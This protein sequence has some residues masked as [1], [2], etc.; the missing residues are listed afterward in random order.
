MP[1]KKGAKAQSARSTRYE[2]AVRE[3]GNSE[4]PEEL[5][6][7]HDS[8]W[9]DPVNYLLAVPDKAGA[10]A[11]KIA[12]IADEEYEGTSRVVVRG[13]LNRLARKYKVAPAKMSKPE[14]EKISG[15]FLIGEI[16]L[17][18]EDLGEDDEHYGMLRIPAARAAVL[19]H[20]WYGTMH[21]DED[22]FESFIDNWATDLVGFDLAIDPSHDTR[23]GALAWVKDVT[24]SEEGQFDL[25]VE[26][27]ADGFGLGDVFRYASIEYTEDYTD[28]ETGASYGPT[29]LGCAAT[30]RPFVHRQ[31][32]IQVLSADVMR[33]GDEEIPEN[34][35]YIV[36][37]NPI[38]MEDNEMTKR[39]VDPTPVA[40]L[41]LE[42]EDVNLNDPVEV[43][44]A[45][46]PEVEPT[47]VAPA[48]AP[49]PAAAPVV[50]PTVRTFTNEQVADVMAQNARL[51]QRDHERSVDEVIETA[52]ARGVAPV[53]LQVARQILNET[54]PMA[55]AT[56]ALTLPAGD[57]GTP[58]Q[59]RVNLHNAVA[60][61]LS[62]VPGRITEEPLSYQHQNDQPPVEG[63]QTNP[64]A[65]EFSGTPEEAEEAARARRKEL[66]I[67][68]SMDADLE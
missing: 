39:Q 13:R 62:L 60:K 22:L 43:T 7:L 8:Q 32:A 38:R 4:K 65:A 41:D 33:H 46:E 27:T 15:N 64:Y 1:R 35:S 59:E 18:D 3:D 24:Y 31:D 67:N 36:L 47:P 29:L 63:D 44:P 21:L 52:S 14:N 34:A 61:M 40:D 10:K 11:A 28:Q 55:V 57:D 20:P 30:N 9:A 49:V 54:E 53:V 58:T 26:P 37:T 5:A 25:W 50:E 66:N 12:F 56:I 68:P 23:K 6:E 2:I 42:V 17:A 51:L 16:Q 19:E 45:V 48:P